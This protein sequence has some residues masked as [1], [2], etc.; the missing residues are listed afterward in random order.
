MDGFFL[1]FMEYFILYPLGFCAL[2]GA[3]GWWFSPKQGL[4]VRKYKVV[5]GY[6]VRDY[7]AEFELARRT[8]R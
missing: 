1:W 4:K 8:R 5:D 6:R 3:V 7:Q 2:I